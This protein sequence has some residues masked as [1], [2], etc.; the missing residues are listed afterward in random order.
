MGPTSNILHVLLWGGALQTNVTMEDDGGTRKIKED[1]ESFQKQ[2]ELPV[3]VRCNLTHLEWLS[4]ELCQFSFTND[5]QDIN[6][7][8]WCDWESVIR[9]YNMLT[10]CLEYL[11][12]KLGC[13]FPNNA[14]Q[15][16]L[17][18]VHIQYFHHCHDQEEGFSDAPHYVAVTLTIVPVCLIPILV[19][20]I[21][22]KSKVRE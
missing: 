18:Q 22:C 21:V 17:L 6:K 19:F 1:D 14:V 4:N 10:L 11:T 15:E 5:M 8:L 2:D 20:L 7:D 9:P 13:F 12:S 16:A 3:I